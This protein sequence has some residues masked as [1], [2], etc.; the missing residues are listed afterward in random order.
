LF[1]QKEFCPQDRYHIKDCS[2]WNHKTQVGPGEY[3]Q[4]RKKTYGQACNAK[5]EVQVA[6]Y[7]LYCLQD[8]KPAE[9]RDIA[10]LLHALGEKN[11]PGG[12]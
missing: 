2:R 1:P 9:R 11:V 10:D 3:G 7:S 8:L 12:V 4:E 5:N 6:R